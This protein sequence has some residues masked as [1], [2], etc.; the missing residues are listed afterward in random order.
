MLVGYDPGRRSG[1]G[2]GAGPESALGVL[3]WPTFARRR[4]H[5]WHALAAYLLYDPGTLLAMALTYAPQLGAT[6]EQAVPCTPGWKKAPLKRSLENGQE[7][8]GSSTSQL[9]EVSG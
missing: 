2:S 4:R 7:Q 1:T 9:S 3:G 6:E 8:K 5:S